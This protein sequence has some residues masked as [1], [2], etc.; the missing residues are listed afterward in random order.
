MPVAADSS[1][2]LDILLNDPG[3]RAGSQAL[4]E[5]HIGQGAVL[6]SSVAFAECAAA[7]RPTSEFA[8]M[9][10]EMGLTFD[11]LDPAVCALAAQ[12]WRIYRSAGGQRRRILADFL[13]TPRCGPAFS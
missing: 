8:R 9:A 12:Q 13:P 5:R 6:L 4:L 2:V 1:V 10:A 7:L 3:F 11:P